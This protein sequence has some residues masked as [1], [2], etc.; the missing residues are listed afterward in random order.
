MVSESKIV[1]GMA[2][3]S[4][5]VLAILRRR[6]EWFAFWREQNGQKPRWFGTRVPRHGVELVG[7]FQEH[8]AHGVGCLGFVAHLGPDLSLE[9]MHDGNARMPVRLRTLARS[10]RD[11]HSRYGPVLQ[12]KVRQIVPE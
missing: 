11:F 10:I 1:M 4:R 9:D 12:V 7:S 3:L 5:F 6:R 2:K 8:L